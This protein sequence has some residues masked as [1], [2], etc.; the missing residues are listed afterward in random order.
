[1]VVTVEVTPPCVHVHNTPAIPRGDAFPAIELISTLCI[2]HICNVAVEA[3]GATDLD[4]AH[5]TL[6][7][8]AAG[9]VKN[10]SCTN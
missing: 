2:D 1:M 9:V 3:D 5:V 4:P 10:E 7:S 8:L 6:N